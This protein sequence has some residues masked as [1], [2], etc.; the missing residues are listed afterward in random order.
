MKH[1]T[2]MNYVELTARRLSKDNSLF[3]DQKRFLESQMLASSSLFKNT[4]RNKQEMRK[5]LFK[6]GLITKHQ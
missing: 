3:A 5:Y 1:L 6:R 4:F 2:D